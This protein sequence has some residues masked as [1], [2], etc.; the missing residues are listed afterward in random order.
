LADI[1]NAFQA[2]DTRSRF[3]PA[4]PDRRWRRLVR[5]FRWSDGRMSADDQAPADDDGLAGHIRAL[6]EHPHP[7]GD[8]RRLRGS[9]KGDGGNRLLQASARPCSRGVDPARRDR[10]DADL[11]IAQ[12][13]GKRACQRDDGGLGAAAPTPQRRDDIPTGRPPVGRP[14]PPDSVPGSFGLLLDQALVAGSL[15]APFPSGRSRGI[16]PTLSRPSSWWGAR[17]VS[18]RPA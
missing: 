3:R 5:A 9:A 14:V 6:S 18:A 11:G 15:R 7:I 16:I 12:F 2:Q 13:D 10:V 17:P 8:L 4:R 1:A